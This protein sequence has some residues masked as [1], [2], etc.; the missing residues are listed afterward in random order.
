VDIEE[1]YDQDERRRTS[2]EIEIG[3]GWTDAQG[4]TYELNWIQDTG[5]LYLMCEAPPHEW[6]DPFGGIHVSRD[7]AD[8][9]KEIEGMTVA[10]LG[11]VATHDQL[12]SVI[13]GWDDEMGRPNS[14]KWLGERLSKAGVAKPAG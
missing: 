4:V 12:E 14:L 2:A 8:D 3:D 9:E 5:E 11:T 10:L 7:A 1:F 13:A 6:A